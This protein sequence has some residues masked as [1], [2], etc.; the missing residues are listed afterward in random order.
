MNGLTHDQKEPQVRVPFSEEEIDRILTEVCASTWWKFAVIYGRDTGLRLGDIATIEW[1]CFKEDGLCTVWTDKK[2]R[3]VSLPM[4]GRM[5]GALLFLP[6]SERYVFPD[7]ASIANDPERRSNLSTEFG[8]ICKQAGII[9]KSFHCLRH[10]YVTE[11]LK[12]NVPIE[13]I[14]RAVGHTTEEMTRRY[15]HI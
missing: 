8:R 3:R 7:R 11:A 9:G 14:S 1:S 5:Q 15:A 2:D 4:T 13:H 12:N 6:K 10:T